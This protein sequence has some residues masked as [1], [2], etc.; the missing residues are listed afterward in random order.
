VAVAD[1]NR[2]GRPD[3]VTANASGS[4][5]VL[6]R[7]GGT[8]EPSRKY[9]VGGPVY[10]VKVADFD[11][12]GELD[13][14]V[15][16]PEANAVA[17]LRNRGDG[18]F[19]PPSRYRAGKG[20]MAVAAGDLDG[21]G[22]PD[23]AVSNSLDNPGSVSILL[24]RGDGT[25]VRKT[26]R[27]VG[28]L[29]SALAI[30]DVTGGGRADLLVGH[31][32]AVTVLVGRG[33]GT[34]PHTRGYEI[35]DQATAVAVADLNG[36]GRPDLVVAENCDLSVWLDRT[37]GILGSRRELA[38]GED[39]PTSV[40]AGDVDGDGR[41][42]LVTAATAYG[43]PGTVSVLLNRGDGRFAAPGTYQVGGGGNDGSDVAI[44]DLEGDGRA[45]IAVTNYDHSFVGVLTNTLG[46]CG[47]RG[48]RG[49]SQ[50][51]ARALLRRAGCRVGSVTRVR[52]TLIPRG[53]VAS[54]EPRFGAFWPNGPEVDLVVS[55]GRR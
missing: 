39:C 45:D 16:L 8:F 42:D 48:F 20:P 25:F 54:A 19:G 47:V 5:S 1:L 51:A 21:D 28:D 29:P 14:A 40:T 37:R 53:R 4:V 12:D 9:R 17:I 34:F 36:N 6:L 50:P 26:K 7:R 10:S 32:R 43:F 55:E 41:I 24:N 31:S 52:S 13:I 23:L 22:A 30:A 11:G 49:K 38:H 18:T 27:A 35:D 15:A 2:D 3:L 44:H 33:D 46:A